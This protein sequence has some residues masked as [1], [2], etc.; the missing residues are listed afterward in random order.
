MLAR[1][2]YRFGSLAVALAL[3]LC[4]TLLHHNQYS[5]AQIKKGKTRLAETKFLMRGA[6]GPNCSALAKLVKDEPKDD[7]G[8]EALAC[9][10]SILNELSYVLLED[11][12]CPDQ[13]WA[14]ACKALRESSSKL[15]D[16]ADAKKLEAAQGA[17]KGVTGSCSACHK[18]HKGK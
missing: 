17:F 8:W 16:A 14:D 9:H 12:R 2:W 3:G 6:V 5:E 4:W 1:K 7:K 13:S 15:R 18:V 11:G 10:A